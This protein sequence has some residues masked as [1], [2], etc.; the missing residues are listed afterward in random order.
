MDCKKVIGYVRVSDS[1]KGSADSQRNAIRAYANKHNLV[2]EDIIEEYISASKTE[3]SERKLSSLVLSGKSIVV[4]DI[5]RIGRKKVMQLIGVIAS[6]AERGALHLAY[7]DRVIDSSNV[8]DAETL[9]T[10]VGQSYASAIEAKKRSERAKAGHANRKSKG[11]PSGRKPGQIVKSKLDEHIAYIIK[12][13]EKGV[14]TVDLIKRLEQE[15]G[16]KVSRAGFYKW[17]AKR[18]L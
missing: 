12:L 13:Q 5:S 7:D 14:T 6:I 17:R 15:K 8:D 10:V 4:S 16:L 1:N 11:L 18:I 2:I 9:F 3:L